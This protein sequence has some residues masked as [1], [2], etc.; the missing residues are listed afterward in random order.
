MALP[1]SVDRR[2]KRVYSL[3]SLCCVTL[4]LSVERRSFIG[5]F[6]GRSV[7]RFKKQKKEP[8]CWSL[9]SSFGHFPY[10]KEEKERIASSDTLSLSLVRR[11]RTV[12]RFVGHFVAF[13]RKK[14]QKR[15]SISSSES[16]AASSTNIGTWVVL[17]N[18]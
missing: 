14:K 18:P 12:I 2:C 17:A 15:E 9:C 10:R 7:G 13:S 6:V 1:L 3:L 5:R 4:S 11:S 8:L 16:T